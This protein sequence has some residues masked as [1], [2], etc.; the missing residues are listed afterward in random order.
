MVG[1]VLGVVQ[2]GGFSGF[3]RGLCRDVVH[4]RRSNLQDVCFIN[5][6]F[7][8][9]GWPWSLAGSN[10]FLGGKLP[11]S[12]FEAMEVMQ[13]HIYCDKSFTWRV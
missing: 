5:T 11:K 8:R 4:L 2:K 3:A 12:G 6:R 1:Q 9:L 10:C 13:D 7:T